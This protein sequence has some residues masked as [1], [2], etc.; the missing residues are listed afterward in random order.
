MEC[1]ICGEKARALSTAAVFVEV[2]CPACGYYGVPRFLV[3]QIL[4]GEWRLDKDRT[5][6]YLAMRAVN[7]Q[8]PWITKIDINIHLLRQVTVPGR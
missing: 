7:K 5:R 3:Q 4:R 8:L 6:T 1:L 2:D